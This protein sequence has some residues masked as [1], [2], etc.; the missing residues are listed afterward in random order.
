MKITD[1]EFY[2]TNPGNRNYTFLRVLTDEGISG[3][4]APYNVGPDN[5]VIGALEDMKEWFIG[6]DPTRIEW[7][8]RRAKNTMRFVLSGTTRPLK[9]VSPL[10]K[11]SSFS[12]R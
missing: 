1:I 11:G 6:Q 8:M 9:K 2:I 3:V 12:L 7:L 4:G 10:N 5:G